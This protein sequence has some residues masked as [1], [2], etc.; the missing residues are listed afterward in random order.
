MT[1]DIYLRLVNVSLRSG[2]LVCKFVLIFFLAKYL[3]PAEVG[4]YGLL[5]AT[6]GYAFFI[7]GIEF[8]TYSSREL[9]GVSSDG[10]LPII[11][12]QWVFFFISYA[13]FIPLA[14]CFFYAGFLPIKYFG[15][16]LILFLL[17][18]T[19]QELNRL[20][21]AMGEQLLA[22]SILFL[23][24]GIWVFFVVLAMWRYPESRTLE[25]VFKAWAAGA[26]LACL[27]GLLRLAML[28]RRK[29]SSRLNWLWI[30]RGIKVSIPLLFASLAIRG[31]FTFDR[32][33]VEAV[34]GMEVLGIY[35]LFAGIAFSIISFIDAGVIVFLYPRV[36]AA[37][38]E[39]NDK[40]F[41]AQMKELARNVVVATMV[42]S[43]S[44]LFISP[45][46]LE[47]IGKPVY[48]E[49]I[50]LL[51]WLLLAVSLYSLSMVPHVGL[52]ARHKDSAILHSQLAG[53]LVFV[54]GCAFGVSRYGEVAVVL[55]MCIAFMVVLVWKC[56]VYKSMHS[57]QASPA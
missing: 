26:S 5:V 57:L 20:F 53:L 14:Y 38:K 7:V 6:I 2:T 42:M 28:D 37:A 34:A 52:Y 22:S 31:L 21:V 46:V 4:T 39:N 23:R 8:Y 47:W 15:W 17:E 56:L 41:R 51:R 9:I 18:H 50:Y 54:I 48:Q 16:F 43:I 10:W 29:L 44:A 45:Y 49:S 30:L 24:S 32:Y 19:A 35:V 36:V 11:R 40:K 25:F 1:K 33:W 27:I 13:C 55:S 12:D 3:P